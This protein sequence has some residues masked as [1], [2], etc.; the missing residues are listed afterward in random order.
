M[1]NFPDKPHQGIR[2]DQIPVSGV[3][4][5]IFAIGIVLLALIGLPEARALGAVGLGGGVI[6]AGVL[7]FW[8]NQTRW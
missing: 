7:Y 6:F 8:H 1:H 4:G 3:G 2:I 5:L